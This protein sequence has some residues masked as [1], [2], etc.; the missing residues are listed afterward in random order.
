MKKLIRRSVTVCLSFMSLAAMAQKSDLQIYVERCQSELQFT[1]SE[2]KPMNCN[3]GPNFATS[4][5]SGINDY[6]VHQ[7][8]Q[9]LSNQNWASQRWIVQ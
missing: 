9:S 3:D 7:R 8:V 2:V 4:S 1:A 5:V 6:V